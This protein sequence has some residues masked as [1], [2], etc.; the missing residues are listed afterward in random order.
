M[1]KIKQY[2]Q[3]DKVLNRLLIFWFVTMPFGS[4]IGEVSLGFFTL[5]WNMLATGLLLPLVFFTIKSWKTSYYIFTAGVGL[6]LARGLFWVGRN[7]LNE[8]ALF[9]LRSVIMYFA[10]TTILFSVATISSKSKLKTVIGG[11]KFYFFTLLAIGV[12][13]FFT[14]THITGTFT[15]TLQT[16]PVGQMD[17][18][19]V[20]V[21]D[22]VNDYLVYLIMLFLL[23]NHLDDRMHSNK[24][25]KLSFLVFFLILS[26]YAS[27]R[28]IMA[29][30]VVWIIVV[31]F[32]LV[33]GQLKSLFSKKKEGWL[34]VVGFV[35]TVGVLIASNNWSEGPM[36]DD[37]SSDR[38]LNQIMV[39]DKTDGVVTIRKASD[40]L[41]R[42]EYSEYIY[43]YYSCGGIGSK[44][45][46]INMFKEGLSYFT[47]NPI[48]GIGPGQ[49]RA[50]KKEGIG[51]FETES[52]HSPH[53]Y[54]IEILSQYGILGIIYFL[55][56]LSGVIIAIYQ[57]RY[58]KNALYFVLVL[59]AFVVISLVPS[60]FLYLDI[61]WIFIPIILGFPTLIE[62][63]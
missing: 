29:I 14:G 57:K 44:A 22:N 24:W 15:N 20:F 31:L 55:A 41:D 60:G 8:D 1:D 56:I 37:H 30:V 6:L 63:S 26:L 35:V 10:F 42:E 3:S 17:Y 45:L 18:S 50:R 9:D 58:F 51:A 38:V 19:P 53:N 7:G 12:F 11:V 21:Y 48:A 27:A 61:N 54:P 43:A 47:E 49:F 33:K 2:Y 5:N 16:L 28:I 46:R 32:G 62:E 34:W 13:E 4:K 25:M 52:L 36:F 40:V 23:W 59:G 39:A